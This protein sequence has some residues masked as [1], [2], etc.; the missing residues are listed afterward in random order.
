MRG[1]IEHT[2]TCGLKFRPM[3]LTTNATPCPLC[4]G[5]GMRGDQSCDLCEGAGR[6]SAI[7]DD[8]SKKKDQTPLPWQDDRLVS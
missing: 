7:K 5:A 1:I 6:I 2:V 8:F 4:L 3:G